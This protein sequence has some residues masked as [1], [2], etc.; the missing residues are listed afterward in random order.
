[1]HRACFRAALA[2]LAQ[3]EHSRLEVQTKLLARGFAHELAVQVVAQL[4]EQGILSEKRY[5]E[6]FV[7]QRV[8]RGQGPLKIIQHL[9]ERGIKEGM[10]AE[11]VSIGSRDWLQRAAEV[12]AKRFGAELPQEAQE[13]AHQSR[14]LQFR[15]FTTEQIKRVLR[16]SDELL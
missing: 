9:R 11:Y 12:R 14:F 7:Y 16:P 3:R 1:M 10:V 15:G 6:T 4:E 13:R 5:V 8:N 2:V